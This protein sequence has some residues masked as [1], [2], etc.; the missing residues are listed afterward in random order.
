MWAAMA[1]TGL[2]VWSLT[3]YYNLGTRATNLEPRLARTL[4]FQ[5]ARD[6]YWG[7]KC[8]DQTFA[9]ED[10]LKAVLKSQDRICKSAFV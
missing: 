5:A 1:R 9:S 7:L 8:P 10:P 6:F 4:I 2:F 3:E